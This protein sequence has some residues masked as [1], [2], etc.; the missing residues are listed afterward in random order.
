MVII[1][2]QLGQFLWKT[3]YVI[4]VHL[5]LKLDSSDRTDGSYKI[6]TD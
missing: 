5:V 2:G 3:E 1:D 6:S 4:V